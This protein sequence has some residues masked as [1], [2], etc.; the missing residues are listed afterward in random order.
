MIS[1][2]ISF[3]VALAAMMAAAAVLVVSAAFGIY[4]LIRTYIGPAGAAGC[5]TLL[6]AILLG[7]LALVMFRKA[8]GP[9]LPAKKSGAASGGLIERLTDLVTDRPVVAASA[10]VAAGLLAW[11][12]PALVSTF[13]RAAEPRTN[14]RKR[15]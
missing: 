7:I 15:R 11:R 9:K 8:K 13:L 6:A 3:V 1:K 2:A 10:A 5:V 4:A 14:D 12:N